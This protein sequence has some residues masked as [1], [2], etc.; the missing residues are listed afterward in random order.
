M[1][2]MYDI[3]GYEYAKFVYRFY[4]K[5]L[6]SIFSS[7]FAKLTDTH[8]HNTRQIK[9]DIYILPRVCKALAQNRLAFRSIKV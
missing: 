8:E 2:K 3:F 1:I 4:N 6:P 7:Y 5:Q 9:K